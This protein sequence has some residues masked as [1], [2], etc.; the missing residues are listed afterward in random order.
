MEYFGT[1]S[2]SALFCAA[3]I[4]DT[5][6]AAKIKNSL[7]F[8]PWAIASLG[9]KIVLPEEL[10]HCHCRSTGPW[11]AQSLNFGHC[12]SRRDGAGF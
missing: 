11:L 4:G 7:T 12:N 6:M 2:E 8:I 9:Y 1:S 3:Q 10:L 5:R